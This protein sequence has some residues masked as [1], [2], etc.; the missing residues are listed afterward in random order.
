MNIYEDRDFFIELE[1][2]SIPWLKVFTK[3]HFL[4]LSDMPLELYMRLFSIIRAVE[5]EMLEYYK[6][7]K[8]NIASFANMLPR[9]HI[10]IMAR[11]E[12]DSHFPNSMW[13]E[14]LRD[15]SLILP[16]QNI[17]LKKL[18]NSLKNL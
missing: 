18:E 7:K 13:G 4:E 3:E 12:N 11:F 14:K 9:V 10:H 16:P 6:P 2:S 1:Q 15:P 8:I 5:L 17:F